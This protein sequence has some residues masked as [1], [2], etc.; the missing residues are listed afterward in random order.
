MGSWRGWAGGRPATDDEALEVVERVLSGGANKTLVGRITKAGGSAVGLSGRD[1]RLLAAAPRRHPPGL[2]R[3]GQITAVHPE[4]GHLL[5]G[6]GFIPGTASV[7]R[8][9]Q[10]GGPRA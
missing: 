6:G 10:G 3:V 5:A 4:I 2:G 9:T 7:G 1:G 8:G